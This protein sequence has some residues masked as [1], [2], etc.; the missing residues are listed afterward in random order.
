M[1]PSRLLATAAA[2]VAALSLAL[3]GCSTGSSN[4]SNAGTGGGDAAAAA[5]NAA[6]PV[7]IKHVYGET[8]IEKAPTRVATLGWSDQ[9]VVLSLGVVPVASTKITYGGNAAG[10]TQWFDAKLKELGGK[11]P[12]RYSDA[13]GIP[14]E[15]VAKATPDLILATNSGITKDEYAK[16]SKIAPTIAYPGDAWGTSWQTS[17]DLIGKALGRSTEAA[18]VKAET[19]AVLKKAQADNPQIVGKT[20]IFGMLSATDTSQ[21]Q[22]YTPLDN[23]PR[24]LTDLGMK[25]APVVEELSKGTKDFSK[26]ISAE[27]ASTL[28]SDVFITY[29]E[30]PG[31]MRKFLTNPLLKQIPAFKT[32]GYVEAANP[33]DVTGMSSPSPLSLPYVVDKFVPSIAQAV[34]RADG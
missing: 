25:T 18:K 28:K 30:K 3:A 12:A 20:V 15:E 1:K 10:S 16:L 9:D 31:E 33:V 21:V 7:T 24:V 6:Y 26:S 17:L 2:T 32:G 8:T 34:D 4:G 19:E 11:Q 5:D 29:T 14:V 22:F 23:R 13:D 27:Q